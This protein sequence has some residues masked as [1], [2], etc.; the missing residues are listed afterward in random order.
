MGL[1]CHGNHQWTMDPVWSLSDLSQ[2]PSCG[3]EAPKEVSAFARVLPPALSREV[4]ADLPDVKVL[5]TP[6]KFLGFGGFFAWIW[7]IWGEAISIGSVPS[8][9]FSWD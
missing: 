3:V 7:W 2:A 5:P 9:R 1:I 6:M 4:P 8:S